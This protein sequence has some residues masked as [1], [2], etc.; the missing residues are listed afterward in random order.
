[1]SIVVVVV[2]VLVVS[3]SAFLLAKSCRF[4]ELPCPDDGARKLMAAHGS[5]LTDGTCSWRSIA[6][7][8][9][10]LRTSTMNYEL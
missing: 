8:N 2:L 10:L 1:V 7:T 3:R 4:E 9:C 6:V 5:L